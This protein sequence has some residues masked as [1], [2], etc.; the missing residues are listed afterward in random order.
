MRA[1]SISIALATALGTAAV[2][3]AEPRRLEKTVRIGYTHL[4]RPAQ[5]GYCSALY[6]PGVEVGVARPVAE[7]VEARVVAWWYQSAYGMRLGATM[8]GFGARTGRWSARASLGTQ[9]TYILPGG[10]AGGQTGGILVAGEIALDTARF[11]RF[12]TE[13]QV[14]YAWF[15]GGGEGGG[16][17][18]VAVGYG[19][20]W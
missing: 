12:T 10:G 7:G 19:V 18:Q 4:D 11:A 3:T 5:C 6:A 8:V 15:L 17:D 14:R 16:A 1:L 9:W 20:V 13:L 2:A